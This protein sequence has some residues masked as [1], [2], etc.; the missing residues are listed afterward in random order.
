MDYLSPVSTNFRDNPDYNT[1]DSA[2]EFAQLQQRQQAIDAMLSGQIS[3]DELLQVLEYQEIDPNEYMRAS[4]AAINHVINNA[5]PI[6]VEGW[7]FNI[8]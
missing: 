6:E 2:W 4:T 5:I 8:S 1:S 3:P 7:Q